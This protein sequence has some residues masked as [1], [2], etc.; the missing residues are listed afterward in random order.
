MSLLPLCLCL[1]SNLDIRLLYYL[2]CYMQ[3][4]AVVF[5]FIFSFSIVLYLGLTSY[6]FLLHFSLYFIF[7]CFPLLEVKILVVLNHVATLQ[8]H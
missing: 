6:F 2:L 1:Q 5:T 8:H 7:S 3:D 4:F